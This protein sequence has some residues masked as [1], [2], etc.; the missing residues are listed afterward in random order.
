MKFKRHRLGKFLF[1]GLLLISL[2]FGVFYFTSTVY[3]IQGDRWLS[4][5]DSD[6][7]I[8]AYNTVIRFDGNSS[9][10]YFKMGRALQEKKAYREALAAYERAWTIN[11]NF[12]ID[13]S[14]SAYLADLGDIFF[15]K[16]DYKSAISAYQKAI[17]LEPFL[18]EAYMKQGEAL[19][20]EKRWMEAEEVLVRAIDMNVSSR[21]AYFALGEA[22]R[23]QSLW[24]KASKAYEKALEIAPKDVKS[25]QNLGIVLKEQGEIWGAI[26]SYNK[27]LALAP[28]NSELYNLKGEALFA[29]DDIQSALLA[30]DKARQ[31]N[32]DDA[33]VY[34]N[35]CYAR[36]QQRE[37]DKVVNYCQ[38][39][40]KLDAGLGD[41]RFILDE[42]ERG[43]AVRNNPKVAQMPEVI[44]S[45]SSD[46]LVNIKRA[47]VKIIVR[48]N[49]NN[50]VGTGWLM[51][52]EGSKGYIV[53][54]R[55][56]ITD[57]TGKINPKARV[58]AEFFS[59]PGPGQ[60][61]KRL[62]AKILQTTGAD[63]WL[64]LGV[65]EVDNLPADI[66]PLS[67]SS[68][69]VGPGMP[70]KVIGNPVNQPNWSMVK[71]KIN[72]NTDKELILAMMMVSGHSGSPVLDNQ[73]GVVGV[74]A[75]AGLFCPRPPAPE[76]L[77]VSLKLG[78]GLAI[79]LDAVKERLNSW[80][81][82]K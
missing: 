20:K 27:A 80:N 9:R 15:K 16:G 48:S 25:Y 36:L 8:E 68:L 13:S 18:S 44:P 29:V 35:I 75:R 82:L 31:L 52:R 11:P 24:L 77:E 22:Y 32:P 17:D 21:D 53:T 78:C 33:K 47:I 3:L 56:V 7:A 79:P 65:I 43:L 54:N 19:N 69:P 30:Y 2:P 61:R 73:N 6:R 46:P 4:E 23:H 74:V 55:H 70:V 62:R 66:Q 10:A 76:P 81:L 58:Y 57:S 5:G 34:K 42:V 14:H 67:L 72:Q 45:R 71:G 51:R 49:S 59:T 40:L 39:A 26:T 60:I 50:S 12:K 64:D 28:K 37:F 1:I 63:D 41:V 38:R